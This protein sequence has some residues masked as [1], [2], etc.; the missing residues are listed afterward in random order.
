MAKA[1]TG[2]IGRLP[3]AIRD[4]VNR[5]LRD[6]VPGPKLIAWLHTLPEVLAVLDEHFR[7]FEENPI[8]PQ[9]LS[10]WRQGGYQE[11]LAQQEKVAQL[12]ELARFAQKLGEAAGGDLTDG[13]A[14][15]LGGKILEKLETATDDDIAGLTKALVAL[16]STDLEARKARQRER[17]LDQ[18]ERQVQLAEK[19]FQ[20][21]SCE[22]FLT[23]FTDKRAQEIAEGK[24]ARPVKI[25]Q[26]RLAMF[27]AESDA[28]SRSPITHRP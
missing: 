20:V 26:L 6:N 13:S 19:Q 24:A 1:R 17:L 15:I 3:L 28:G 4:E 23:W 16:R 27:G 25:E 8:S 2:K 18:K 14:A 11:W 7:G 21:R 10:E 22:L 12:G 5:Q 9:N